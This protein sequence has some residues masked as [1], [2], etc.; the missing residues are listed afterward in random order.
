MKIV[1][2]YTLLSCMVC[3]AGAGYTDNTIAADI[4]GQIQPTNEI[5]PVT[6]PEG[7][8]LAEIEID[9]S[10]YW[11][12]DDITSHILPHSDPEQDIMPFCGEV[13]D[14]TP[15]LMMVMTP[16]IPEPATLAILALGAM[17]LLKRK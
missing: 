3:L 10:T 16:I 11:A 7:I 15:F 2:V 9:M 17:T 13:V 5:V 4:L 12:A 1:C 14:D 8:E 6:N